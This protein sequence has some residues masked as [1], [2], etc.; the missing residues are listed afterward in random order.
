MGG[1]WHIKPNYRSPFEAFIPIQNGCDKFCTFCA[2]PYTRGR[3]I[4]R[5]SGE[6]IEEVRELIGRGYRASPCWGKM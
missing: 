3:E 1:F 2:V 4:S 6:I 5:P